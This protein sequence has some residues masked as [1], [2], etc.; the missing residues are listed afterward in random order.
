M[1]CIKRFHLTHNLLDSVNLR[2]YK[3]KNLTLTILILAFSISTLFGQEYDEVSEFGAYQ[4]DWAQVQK[5]G[6][7]GFIDVDG[8]E[9][10]KPKYEAISAFG[11]YQ[12]D[13]A[14]IQKD[15]L[16]GF[17]DSKGIEIVKPRYDAIS[18][19]GAYQKDWALVQKDGL[20]GFI[21]SNGKEIVKAKYNEIPSKE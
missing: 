5:D 7:Y 3:I 19:F 12:K 8:N 14:Q 11:A 16:Y 21:D 18:A 6:L 2:S 15:G 1:R 13:W 4:K 17:I 9:I 10:V 20:Y